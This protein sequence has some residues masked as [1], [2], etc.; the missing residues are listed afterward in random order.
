M[1][2]LAHAHSNWSYDSSLS[3]SEWR[4][5]AQALGVGTVLLT[6]HEDGGWTTER[7]LDYVRACREASDS[8]VTLV[9]GL[10]FS[11]DGRHLLCYG[12]V[13]LPPR[14]S[15]PAALA[16]AVRAQGRWLCLAHPPK[17]RWRYS[18]AILTAADAVEVWN[19]KWIYDGMLGPHPRSLA[20]ASGKL[21]LAGQDVHRRKHFS[22]LL[23]ETPTSDVLADLAAG[24]YVFRIADT[25]ISVGSLA[26]R[27]TAGVAQ[28]L[29]TLALRH[30][31]RANRV[32]RR[33]KFRARSAIGS[34]GSRPRRAESEQ[35]APLPGDVVPKRGE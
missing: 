9:P 4:T 18:D 26:I 10:E 32:F 23:M 14:P 21:W 13:D 3:L 30:A 1:R 16:E 12:L 22:R 2:V 5:L 8:D 7:Y 25:S 31:L 15:S 35:T 17:Y 27:R 24:R 19:S 29:R 6:D 28:R 11:Q 33:L 34:T 20:L